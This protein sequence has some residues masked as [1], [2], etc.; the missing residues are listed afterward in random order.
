MTTLLYCI[1]Q[2]L[3]TL[4]HANLTQ[5]GDNTST[6]Y[7]ERPNEL[8]FVMWSCFPSNRARVCARTMWENP[9]ATDER[10]MFFFFLNCICLTWHGE[11]SE[12]CVPGPPPVDS[13]AGYRWTRQT[14][15]PRSVSLRDCFRSTKFIQPLSLSEPLDEPPFRAGHQRTGRDIFLTAARFLM[16]SLMREG[17]SLQTVFS[18][19]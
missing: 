13:P 2:H 10:K 1:W 5:A 18:L 9:K 14:P 19:N 16:N 15:P 11:Q 12:V 7:T 4:T 6:V 3:R 17:I 8:V